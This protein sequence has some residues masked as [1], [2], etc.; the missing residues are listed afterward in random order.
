MKWGGEREEKISVT[1]KTWSWWCPERWRE[2]K[3]WIINRETFTSPW[4]HHQSPKDHPCHL[5]AAHHLNKTKGCSPHT[6]SQIPLAARPWV[7]S[8]PTGNER[9]NT[10]EVQISK[11]F[12]S[13]QGYPEWKF[14]NTWNKPTHKSMLVNQKLVEPQ[15]WRCVVSSFTSCRSFTTQGGFLRNPG[16]NSLNK[17]RK[18]QLKLFTTVNCLHGL[19][20]LEV[21]HKRPVF[22]CC[23]FQV[24]LW[25]QLNVNLCFPKIGF[26]HKILN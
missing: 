18:F 20:C 15:G 21:N 13:C 10:F 24:R 5:L 25:V 8:S 2:S 1:Q 26:P 22:T 6:P 16:R 4:D 3:S 17:S 19:S 12:R 9:E 23:I 11:L 14:R 7:V